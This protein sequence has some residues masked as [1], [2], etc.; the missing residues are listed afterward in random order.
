MKKRSSRFETF[1]DRLATRNLA[2]GIKP[3]LLIMLLM[4]IISLSVIY[5]GLSFEYKTKSTPDSTNSKPHTIR[6][7]D[8]L[9]D[10]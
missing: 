8:L 10:S 3:V 6:L 9:V 1:I 2:K 4:V 7:L 5:Y